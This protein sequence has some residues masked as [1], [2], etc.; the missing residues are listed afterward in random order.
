M[1]Q[2]PRKGYCM[3]CH[4]KELHSEKKLPSKVIQ[5]INDFLEPKEKIL[6][7]YKGWI[8]THSIGSEISTMS[9]RNKIGG[10]QMRSP[11]IIFTNKRLI[12]VGVGLISTDFRE[13][14]YENIKSIDYEQRLLVDK[15]T[16]FAHSCVE[17]IEFHRNYRE[18]TK[19]IPL[20]IKK[21]MKKY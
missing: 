16:I 10:K 2:S 9:S 17:S 14:P 5:R 1:K 6:H 13:I 18:R 20:L 21:Y 4:Q 19:E 7:T 3:K 15:I 12:F 8:C 11:W